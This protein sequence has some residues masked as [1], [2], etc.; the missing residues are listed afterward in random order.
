MGGV[1]TDT[2]IHMVVKPSK[3]AHK[4]LQ[5]STQYKIS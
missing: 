4:V 5:N 1:K 3:L 2:Y